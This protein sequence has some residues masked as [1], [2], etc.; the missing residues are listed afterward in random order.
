MTSRSRCYRWDHRDTRN[1][2]S[3]EIQGFGKVRRSTCP[4]HERSRS[5]GENSLMLPGSTRCRLLS[6]LLVMTLTVVAG[7]IART[8][9]AWAES[10]PSLEPFEVERVL[11]FLVPPGVTVD[12][13]DVA[14][15]DQHLIVEVMISGNSQ[16]AVTDLNGASYQCISCGLATNATKIKAI[17]DG[18]RVWFANTSG[19]QGGGAGH[20]DY[21]I[22]ECAPSIYDCQT[23][24]MKKVQFPAG[25]SLLT[26]QNR[27]AKPDWY[28]EY[29]TWNE[30]NPIRGTRMSIAKLTPGGDQ[31][32]LTD[33]RV[34]NP[35]WVKRTHFAADLA[36]AAHFYEGAS[37][38]NGG[39][40]LKYQTT[41]TGLNYDIWLLDTATGER[42]PLTS[43]LDY[44]EAGEIAPDGKT[45]YFSS[46]RGLN[47]MTVFTQLARP[48]L[49]DSASFG[50]IGRVG[51]WNNRRCMNEPW[52][53]DTAIGQQEGGYS[54]QPIVID[55]AWTIRGWSWFDDSTR[56]LVNEQPGPGGSEK[57]TRISILKFPARTPT[58]PQPPIHQDPAKIAQWSVPVKD[59]NPLMGRIMPM[60]VLKGK[61]SG[62]AIVSYLG[63]YA[64]G[65]FSV[66]Y[67][68]YSDDGMTFL[69]GVESILVVLAPLTATW[70]ANLTSSG[71]RR[72]YLR[73]L[74]IVGPDNNYLGGVESSINGQK[75]AGIPTQKNCP[76][77]SQPP[78][79]ISFPAGGGRVMVTAT[80]P[81]DSQARPVRGATVSVGPVTMTTNDEGVAVLPLIQGAT[82][83]ALAGGF[84][85]AT[86]VVGNP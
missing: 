53:M 52:L 42:R 45:T 58:V 84:Q 75:L 16:I 86:R 6:L 14:P 69:N 55:P 67:A 27:E 72:G 61:H 54:G 11:S 70:T 66:A 35:L 34:F 85:S 60:R 36:N 65:K 68:N 83:T 73:G 41:S 8:P 30:V 47:R 38:N 79:A 10:S 82:V 57:Q 15:D 44:N 3:N 19:Q 1:E 39:R 13:A 20:I 40:T 5:E 80:I 28:G 21:Q 12:S 23:K 56:A 64:S 81:E 18:K 77:R 51:L 22:L 29:V 74:V 48:A 76:A 2:S 9:V 24:A 49:I 43:D 50:Q 71:A 46:A 33:Q 31:Y 25:G 62:T 37:W 59:F 63:S 32:T 78:L 17:G 26:G 7:V 4:T